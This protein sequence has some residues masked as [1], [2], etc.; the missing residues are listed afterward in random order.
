MKT[1]ISAVLLDLDGTLLDHRGAARDAFFAACAHWLPS[2]DTEARHQAYAVWQQLEDVHM[3]AYLEKAVTFQEQ[4][5]SRVRDLLTAHGSAG[6][7]LG[8][9]RVDDLFSVYLRHYEASWVR[10]DDVAEAMRFLWRAPAGVAVLSNGDRHQQ[11]AKMHSL[12]LS[13]MPPLFTPDE[14]GT[15]KPQAASFLGV[16]GQMGWDP[17]EVLYIGDDLH[18]DAIAATRA[19][20]RGC[21]LDRQRTEAGDAPEGILRVH[22]LLDVVGAVQ[23]LSC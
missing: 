4:R 11:L 13:P 16:C 3:K 22:S 8:D 20:L 14:V 5:R 17:A 6:E 19:G 23:W 2:L 12:G 18:V 21:W 10:Y 7:A 9:G 15:P 1:P